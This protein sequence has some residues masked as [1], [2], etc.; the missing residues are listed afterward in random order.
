M[1][2]FLLFFIVQF[3]LYGLL[4]LNYRSAANIWPLPLVFTDFFIAVINFKVIK[5]ITA[6]S[7]HGP[8]FWGYVLGGVLGSLV[9]MYGS[10]W[11]LGK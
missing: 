8:A 5:R 10:L 6:Q 11:V 3:F 9:S 2:Q 1:K 4:V 7:D